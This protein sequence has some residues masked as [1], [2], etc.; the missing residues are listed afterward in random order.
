MGGQAGCCTK[1]LGYSQIAY[2]EINTHARTCHQ[3][4]G[5]VRQ[6]TVMTVNGAWAHGPRKPADT[7]P[8][9]TVPD[10]TLGTRGSRLGL[11]Q[12]ISS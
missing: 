8:I 9:Q 1:D 10:R 4:V 2:K 5:A 11:Q 7:R 12:A 6:R 3:G